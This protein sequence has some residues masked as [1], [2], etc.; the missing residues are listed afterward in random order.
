MAGER[1]VQGRG[2]G[3]VGR[4]GVRMGGGIGFWVEVGVGVGAE[5]R[6]EVGVVGW[7]GCGEELC[8]VRVVRNVSARAA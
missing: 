4:H 8:A 1:H 7:I 3:W 5:D 2:A 6:V